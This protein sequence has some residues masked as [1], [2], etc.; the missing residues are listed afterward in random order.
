MLVREVE[1][2]PVSADELAAH[3]T[4][5]ENAA[6]EPVPASI[7]LSVEPRPAR[8][9]EAPASSAQTAPIVAKPFS[10]FTVTVEYI[11]LVPVANAAAPE[12]PT[13]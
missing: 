12:K 13:T 11:Q 2:E 9:A 5:E 7:V 1:V 10:K 4:P 3:A 8:R 6:A